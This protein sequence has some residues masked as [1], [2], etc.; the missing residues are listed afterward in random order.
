MGENVENLMLE[1][2]RAI[3]AGQDRIEF[4]VK[5]VKSRIGHLENAVLGSRR[6]SVGTQEDVYRQQ[7]TMDKLG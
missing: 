1:Q 7:G 2:L 4:D 6:D 5:E 3:R